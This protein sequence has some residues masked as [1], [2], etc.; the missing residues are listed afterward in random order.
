MY[1]KNWISVVPFDLSFTL[2]CVP[3]SIYI[4]LVCLLLYWSKLVLGWWKGERER[5]RENLL[6]GNRYFSVCTVRLH[7]AAEKKM[8]KLYDYCIFCATCCTGNYIYNL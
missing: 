4:P 7:G 3:Y 1:K 6:Q 8:K 2:V 5:E